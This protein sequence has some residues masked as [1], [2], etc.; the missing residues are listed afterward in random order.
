ME[1][2]SLYE[3]F[4]SVPTEAQKTIKGGRLN[5]F[6]DINPMWR[7]K[8]LTEK[9]GAC[10]F[11][12][13]APIKRTW[14]DGGANGEVIAN[15]EIELFVKMGDEWSKGIT[16]IGGSKYIAKEN[17]GLYTDDECYKKAYTDAISV[18][19]KALGMGADIYWQNDRT[20]YTSLNDKP[21]NKDLLDELTGLG[22]KIADVAVYY[23][24]DISALTD[25]DL[26]TAIASKKAKMAKE[27][28]K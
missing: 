18:A 9:F 22:V 6:T 24:K 2:L 27:N 25:E 4:R 28:A 14:L 11:G 15:V 3:S 17:G 21:L 20:K 23:K 5:G 7:I 26:K 1:N 19:C 16:G 12:W 8:M 13:I 10:G